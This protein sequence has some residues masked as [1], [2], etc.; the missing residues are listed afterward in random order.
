MA[1][2]VDHISMLLNSMETFQDYYIEFG[3][4]VCMYMYMYQ[5]MFQ[6]LSSRVRFCLMIYFFKL[7][8][9]FLVKY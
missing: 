8:L 1:Y 2:I 3:V 9:N 6:E 4:C 7:T 5:H